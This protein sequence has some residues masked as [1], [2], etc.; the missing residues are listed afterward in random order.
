MYNKS[1]WINILKIAWV[2]YLFK[3]VINVCR[4]GD[5]MF[6]W[7]LLFNYLDVI[8]T[9]STVGGGG[10]Y[11]EHSPPPKKKCLIPPVFPQIWVKTRKIGFFQ[12]AVVKTNYF[13]RILTPLKSVLPR[14][15]L[16]LLLSRHPPPHPKMLVPP[17]VLSIVLIQRNQY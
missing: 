6:Q 1:G 16:P 8:S 12:Y 14:F 9:G 4:A 5:R 7:Y 13:L 11:G 15:F 2:W 10:R 3:V 17:L